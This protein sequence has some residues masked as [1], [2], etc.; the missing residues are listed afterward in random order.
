MVPPSLLMAL[1]GWDAGLLPDGILGVLGLSGKHTL[2][3]VP[4][5]GVLPCAEP[6]TAAPLPS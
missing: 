3:L 2:G 1:C 5:A 4:G 6:S